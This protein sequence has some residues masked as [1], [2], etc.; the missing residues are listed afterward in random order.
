MGFFAG[1]LSFLFRVE[2]KKFDDGFPVVGWF[3]GVIDAGFGKVDGNLQRIFENYRRRFGFVSPQIVAEPSSNLGLAVVV[4]VYDEPCLNQSFQSLWD[5]ERPPCDVEVLLVFNSSERDSDAVRL[6]NQQS[7]QSAVQWIREHSDPQFRCYVLNFPRLPS[8]HAGVGLA[9]KIGMDEAAA[10]FYQAKKSEQGVIVCYDADCLCERNFLVENF[11]HF[12]ERP[13]VAGCSTYFEHPLSGAEEPSVYRAVAD[14]ELHLR[15]Y[16]EGLRWAGFPYAYHT[17]GSAMSVRVPT[18]LR[19]GGMNRKKAGEDFY[20]FQKLMRHAKTSEL[21][22]TAVYPSARPSHRVPF[23]TGRAVGRILAGEP[24]MSYSFR[25]FGSVKALVDS[26]ESLEQAP[27][28]FE[29]C[30]PSNLPAPM[31]AFLEANNCRIAIAEI[32]KNVA[33]VAQFKKRFWR[34]FDGFR[35]VKFLNWVSANDCPKVETL[36][37]AAEPCLLNRLG[38]ESESPQTEVPLLALYRNHQRNR[39]S[40]SVRGKSASN[41]FPLGRETEFLVNQGR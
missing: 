21:C 22:A 2:A 15:Y 31:L 28:S 6:R 19:L 37:A 27:T 24:Q 5:C 7:R 18:Y 26:V 30:F 41:V 33:G 36:T 4:P 10:R 12:A 32:G 40:I 14:Y 29:E 39:R 34:W 17:V 1:G 9:R 25:A 11:R 35:C 16:V 20:F 13:G 8:K 23:G 3:C 38:M